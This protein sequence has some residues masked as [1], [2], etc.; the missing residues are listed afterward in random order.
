MTAGWRWPPWAC[1]RWQPASSTYDV[2]WFVDVLAQRLVTAGPE[3]LCDTLALAG[4]SH[5][6]GVDHAVSTGS[7]SRP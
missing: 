4:S 2:S 5:D 7:Q 3:G 1:C 6:A